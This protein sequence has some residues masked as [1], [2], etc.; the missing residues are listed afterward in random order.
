LLD[1]YCVKNSATFSAET[2]QKQLQGISGFS[3]ILRRAILARKASV[4]PEYQ[5]TIATSVALEIAA[6][7]EAALLPKH[8]ALFR[9]EKRNEH[10]LAFAAKK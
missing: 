2:S 7:L 10:G 5:L 6:I 8:V 1:N 3:L 4:I 9:P